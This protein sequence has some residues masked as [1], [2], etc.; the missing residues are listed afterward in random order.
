MTLICVVLGGLFFTLEP[1][2][3]KGAERRSFLLFEGI[4]PSVVKGLKLEQ[5]E[6]MVDL[7]QGESSWEV[8]DHANYHAADGKVRSLL[9]KLLSLEVSQRI[10]AAEKDFDALGVTEAKIKEGRARVT[11]RDK[12]GKDVVGLFLGESRKVERGE[13][14]SFPSGQYVR[15]ADQSEVYLVGEPITIV[16]APTD[17]LQKDLT[18]VLASKVFDI[19]QIGVSGSGE[20][21][22][23]QLN[24]DESSDESN[25]TPKFLS[26]TPLQPGESLDEAALGQ[27]RAGLENLRMENVFKGEGSE[28]KDLVFDKKTIYRTLNGEVYTIL[29][30]S[31]EDKQYIK[32]DVSFDTQ[33]ANEIK[34]KAEQ[35][36]KEK[37]ERE[38]AEKEKQAATASSSSQLSSSASSLPAKPLPEISSA[39]NAKKI[40]EKF[41]GWVYEVSEFGAKKFRTE[42][43]D[44]FVKKE[45]PKLEEPQKTSQKKDK[46]E[47]TS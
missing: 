24:R 22:Q 40:D 8:V 28:V 34:V 10:G 2:S 14:L 32:L 5:G 37:E 39:E 3:Q 42:R 38:K 6:S 16:A 33:L 12:E 26:A 41:E 23:F 20:E 25:Q 43:K 21:V 47:Q 27:I 11:L 15:R 29:S 1:S 46:K 35:A 45:A 7:R 44:L 19:T 9:L 30:A 13:G 36:A 4:D 17:W 18:N 31:K